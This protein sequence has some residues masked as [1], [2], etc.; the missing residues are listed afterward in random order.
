[1]KTFGIKNFKLDI[2][3]IDTTGM[4]DLKIRAVTLCLEQ[5]YIFILNPS[6]NS[7]KVAVSKP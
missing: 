3:K 4:K 1:M 6:L 7:I 2:Y 5:Y